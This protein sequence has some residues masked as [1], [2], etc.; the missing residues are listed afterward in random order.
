MSW[1]DTGSN[2]SVDHEVSFTREEVLRMRAEATA[3]RAP[4]PAEVPAAPRP[5]SDWRRRAVCGQLPVELAMKWFFPERGEDVEPAKTICRQC[6]VVEECLEDA[7]A[8][9]F[10]GKGI[11]GGMSEKTRW[12]LLR[13]RKRRSA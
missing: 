11:R 2:L 12:Q 6:P 4:R 8:D 5:A 13:G 9:G 10:S 3:P 7:L 1:G